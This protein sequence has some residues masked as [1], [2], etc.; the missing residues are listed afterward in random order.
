TVAELPNRS[1]FLVGILPALLVLWIRRAVPEPEEWKMAKEGS[2]GDQPGFADL[3]RGSVRRTT[4]LVILVCAS[5]LSAHWASMFWFPQHLRNLPDV[6]D[7]T[8]AQRSAL[9]SSGLGIVMVASIVGNFI[10]GYLAKLIGFR[11]ALV[12]MCVAYF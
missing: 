8:E 2:Q 11:L 4:I 6:A 3:F 12:T 5:A 10:A 1:V 9:A 7:W